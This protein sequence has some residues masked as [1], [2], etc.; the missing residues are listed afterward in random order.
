MNYFSNITNRIVLSKKIQKTMSHGPV[1][2]GPTFLQYYQ[3]LGKTN[4]TMKNLKTTTDIH[5]ISVFMLIRLL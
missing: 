1:G 4:G 2:H 5:F 3:P